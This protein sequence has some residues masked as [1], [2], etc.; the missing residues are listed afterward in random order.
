MIITH[1]ISHGRLSKWRER[2][3]IF[4]TLTAHVQ[5]ENRSDRKQT[6]IKKINKTYNLNHNKY[7]KVLH[8]NMLLLS[9]ENVFILKY[10]TKSGVTKQIK[11][12]AAPLS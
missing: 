6:K 2:Q 3:S 12:Y 9:Q 5:L 11:T 10:Q 7:N 4:V 1:R 8:L